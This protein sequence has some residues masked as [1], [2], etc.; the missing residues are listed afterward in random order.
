MFEIP[1]QNIV[2]SMGRSDS[3]MQSIFRHLRRNQAAPHKSNSN[4]FN[5]PIDFK[6]T[7]IGDGI[8]AALSRFR[9]TRRTFANNQL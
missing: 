4:L 9:V 1:C 3:N 8:Q 6:A 7:D 5:P 2:R